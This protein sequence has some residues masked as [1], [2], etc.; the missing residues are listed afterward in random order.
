MAKKTTAKPQENAV[1]QGDKPSYGRS[2]KEHQFK[3]GE[4]G[5]P[6]GPPKHRTHETLR[7]NR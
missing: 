3:P 5:N 4:S 2:P 6:K 1:R 7:T